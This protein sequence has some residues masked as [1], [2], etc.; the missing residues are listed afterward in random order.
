MLQTIQ[1]TGISTVFL[2]QV[3]PKLFSQR[4]GCTAS[5]TAIWDEVIMQAKENSERCYGF[6]STDLYQQFPWDTAL[7]CRHCTDTGK[8]MA[9]QLHQPETQ[10]GEHKEN[11]WQILLECGCA[12]GGIWGG[13]GTGA[14]PGHPDTRPR[15][16]GCDQQ[17]LQ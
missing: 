7:L 5:P 17:H 11:T 14:A 1:N 6:P 15:L 16:T 2:R 3:L 4:L 13:S 8:R 12:R 9:Q 10:V